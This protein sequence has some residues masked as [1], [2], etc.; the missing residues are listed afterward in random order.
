MKKK[1]FFKKRHHSEICQYRNTH[2]ASW[3]MENTLFLPLYSD[4][5]SSVFPLLHHITPLTNTLFLSFFQLLMVHT[6]TDEGSHH[7]EPEHKAIRL[8]SCNIFLIRDYASFPSP[9]R[10][11]EITF[12]VITQYLESELPNTFPKAVFPTKHHIFLHHSLTPDPSKN[13]NQSKNQN[14]K[15]NKK[16][17]PTRAFWSD[18]CN[19]HTVK[20]IKTSFKADIPTYNYDIY[21]YFQVSSASLEYGHTSKRQSVC[22]LG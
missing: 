15:L 20:R 13:P 1:F 14:T 5:Q 18:S 6:L 16:I 4:A 12:P 22:K 11:Y 8:V 17:P 19:K 3:Q 9:P 7:T 2:I 21:N 10:L